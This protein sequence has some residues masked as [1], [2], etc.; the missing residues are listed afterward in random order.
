LKALRNV[1]IIATLAA[2]VVF[3]PGGGTGSSVV[4]QVLSI[5]ILALLAWFAARFYREQRVA[6]YSLGD[7][8]RAILYS[9]A[10]LATLTICASSRLFDSGP[11]TVLW[12]L[13]LALAA[14]GGVHVVRA[15]REQW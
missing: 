1:A 12:I 15:S 8:N 7:R 4:G 2:I 10:G 6:L 9:S 13:L 5:A 11:G 14:A 3:V